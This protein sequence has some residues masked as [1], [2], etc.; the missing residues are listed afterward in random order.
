VLR[1][2]EFQVRIV[3]PVAK[4]VA[5]TSAI[6]EYYHDLRTASHYFPHLIF[7]TWGGKYVYCPKKHS[8]FM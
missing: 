1:K 6:F 4:P 3:E 2:G 5:P 8:G 7:K